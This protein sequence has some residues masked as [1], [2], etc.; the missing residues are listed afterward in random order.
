MNYKI[1]DEDGCWHVVPLA[2]MV[3]HVTYRFTKQFKEWNV[4]QTW[5]S[6]NLS[7]W[8]EMDPTELS[9]SP[10]LLSDDFFRQSQLRRS[11]F[12]GKSLEIETLALAL[13][14]TLKLHLQ[15]HQ[16]WS[17]KTEVSHL[18][19]K[20]QFAILNYEQNPQFKWS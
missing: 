12:S 19:M 9:V 18:M 16:I 5:S 1:R 11:I 8:E 20:T 10:G 7:E 13:A 4:E 15:S 14:L 6:E 3:V 17:F 2:I